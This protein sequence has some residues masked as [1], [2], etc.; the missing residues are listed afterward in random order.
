MEQAARDY[1]KEILTNDGGENPK[2]KSSKYDSVD[3]RKLNEDDCGD[4]EEELRKKRLEQLKNAQL[5]RVQMERI[6]HGSYQTVTEKEFLG[7]VTESF[8]VVVHFSHDEF[9]RCKILDKHLTHLAQKYFKTRFVKANAPD[10]PFFTEKLSVKVLPCLILFKNG[11]AFDRIV[12]FEELGGQDDYKT[13]ALEKR[14]LE[15]GSIEDLDNN[16][17]NLDNDDD[18]NDREDMKDEDI[19]KEEILKEL[20][21]RRL[22]KGFHKT[23]SDE[24]SDFS[25]C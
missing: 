1:Q 2:Q 10:C 11:V 8:T 4:L 6:G 3:L 18:G 12:G 7:A 19:D 9:E 16:L 20:K 14:L 24:D 25:D 17:D 23:E 21:S 5:V 13:Q 22:K 15:V